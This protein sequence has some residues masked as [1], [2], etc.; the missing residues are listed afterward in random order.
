MVNFAA[1]ANKKLADVERPP[2]PPLGMYRFIVTKPPQIEEIANGAYT[3]VTFISKALEA[4]ENVDQE[5]LKEFG[6]IGNV[7]SSVKFLFDNNDTTKSGNTQ[8]KLR[9]FIEKHC[10]VEGVADMTFGEAIAKAFNTQFDGEI[11]HRA[12]KNDPEV[13]YAEIQRTAPIRE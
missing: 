12:D 2:I 6:G 3:Q 9:Q 4:Y 10:A 13:K 11:K 5:E 7:I 8:F 1:I